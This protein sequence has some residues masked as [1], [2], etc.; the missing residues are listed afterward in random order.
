MLRLL[1]LSVSEWQEEALPSRAL[2][3]RLGSLHLEQHR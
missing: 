3:A 2:R 1:V